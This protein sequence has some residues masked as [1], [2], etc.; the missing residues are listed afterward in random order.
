MKADK[1]LRKALQFCKSAWFCLNSSKLYF[2][3]I[4][5]ISTLFTKFRLYSW[6]CIST[7]I[8][9][10]QLFWKNPS[11]YNKLIFKIQSSCQ[12]G[13]RF[14][15][16]TWFTK[17]L[18]TLWDWFEISEMR[19]KTLLSFTESRVAQRKRAG[20]ITQRSVDRNHALLS[21]F[22]IFA[23]AFCAGPLV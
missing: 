3:F 1:L 8:L 16:S 14:C 23:V 19:V 2:N 4:L 21:I 22:H 5:E 18:Q 12:S 10:F 15:R 6:N 11:P 17:T 7:L 20:P 13:P 9:T